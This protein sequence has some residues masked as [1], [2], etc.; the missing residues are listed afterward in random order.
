MKKLPKRD[1]TSRQKRERGTSTEET[2]RSAFVHMLKLAEANMRDAAEDGNR[3][4]PRGRKGYARITIGLPFAARVD[5]P[6]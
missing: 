1:G 5:G 6:K 3:A 4:R 2:I